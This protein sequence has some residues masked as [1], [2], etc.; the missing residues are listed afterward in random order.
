MTYF[1]LDPPLETV[2]PFLADFGAGRDL[3]AEAGL[4][5][6]LTFLAGVAFFFASRTFFLG[7]IFLRGLDLFLAGV[8]VL[9]GFLACKKIG[10]IIR[11]YLESIHKWRHANL[12]QD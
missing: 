5:F 1:L 6:G 7:R 9:L 11:K 12:T 8:D 2:R 10:H 3:D 4:D